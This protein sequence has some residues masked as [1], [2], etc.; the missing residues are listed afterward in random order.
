MIPLPRVGGALLAHSL[1][2]IGLHPAC[3]SVLLHPI[4]N[5]L[6]DGPQVLFVSARIPRESRA[7][8]KQTIWLTNHRCSPGCRLGR[9]ERANPGQKC[10][11]SKRERDAPA[12]AGGTPMY[13]GRLPALRSSFELALQFRHQLFGAGNLA[14]DLAGGG[15]AG[16][17]A[18][19]H[20]ALHGGSHIA[21]IG[22]PA[23][24]ELGG[25]LGR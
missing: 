22:I 9:P 21:Q 12:T 20:G 8:R 11:N 10:R 7:T 19:G 5:E 23:G 15:A 24:H 6:P 13:R 17:I 25:F 4:P 18:A 16:H 14:S 3:Q 2:F 1:N